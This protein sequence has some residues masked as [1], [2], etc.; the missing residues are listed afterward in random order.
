MINAEFKTVTIVLKSPFSHYLFG[1]MQKT[2]VQ[3]NCA[4]IYLQWNSKLC[5]QKQARGLIRNNMQYCMTVSE[6][7]RSQRNEKYLG[8]SQM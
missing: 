6:I 3:E 7:H 4:A 1:P 8:L 5:N 2:L